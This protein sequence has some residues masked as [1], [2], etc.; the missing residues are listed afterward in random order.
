[1][2]PS[3]F[4]EKKAILL[5]GLFL[6]TLLL[7]IAYFR[8]PVRVNPKEITSC[9]CYVTDDEIYLQPQGFNNPHKKKH[10]KVTARYNEEESTLYVSCWLKADRTF[11]GFDYESRKLDRKQYGKIERM[12]L[13]GGG[14]INHAELVI[15]EN[16]IPTLP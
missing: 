6:L 9:P 4:K 10:W 13:V 3:L 14:L 8:V 15:W 7:Y 2:I 16:G 1:M 5:F 11:S 12:V